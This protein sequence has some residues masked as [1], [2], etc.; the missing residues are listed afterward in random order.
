[1]SDKVIQ[2]DPYTGETQEVSK[3][4]TGLPV[5]APRRTNVDAKAARR[6]ERQVVALFTLSALGT[7]GF[8][9]AFFA[10]DTD[11]LDGDT[12]HN[13][14]LGVGMGISLLGIG[15][16]AIHWAR[17][18]MSDDEIVS[19]RH[20]L[21]SSDDDRA[22]AA[23]EFTQGV[24]RSGFA[25]RSMIRRSLFGAMGLLALPPLVLLRDLGPLPHTTLR[26][27]LW[28]GGVRIVDQ[29]TGNPVRPEDMQIGSL[30]NV[31]PENLEDVPHE[32]AERINALA[33][34]A[35]FLVR[36]EPEDIRTQQGDNWDYQGIVAYSKICTHVGC[37]IS[38]YEQQTHHLLCP[39]HQ[40]TFDIADSGNVVFGPAARRL[41]QLA[42]RVDENGYLEAARGFAEPVGPSFWER[43]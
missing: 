37:P 15:I 4:S 21:R 40:S 36:L 3:A 29:V 32:E 17:K 5:H 24:E 1:M 13:R 8:L 41:P 23:A 14:L 30:V 9:V 38:L 28:S 31:V 26:K 10:I 11:T 18:L 39:C 34:A 19:A 35:V 43:G 12:W 33:K 7:V 22:G 2:A 6:A 20:S 42:I 27:T 16:G 25:R